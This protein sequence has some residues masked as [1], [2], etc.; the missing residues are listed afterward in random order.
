M[1]LMF[2]AER[3]TVPADPAAPAQADRPARAGAAAPVRRLSV[4][5][6]AY[7]EALRLP[8]F[9]ESIRL[10]FSRTEH[11]AY[12]V[13]VVD[14]GSREGVGPAVEAIARDWPQ[15][16]LLRHP[17]NRGKGAA[18]RTGITAATG[19]AVL[20]ADA[21]GATPIAEEAKLRTALLR[22]ADLAAGSR[23]AADPSSSRTRNPIRGLAGR[24]FAACARLALDL[25][26]SDPQCGFKMV[27]TD[28]A[29]ELLADCDESGYLFDTQLLLQACRRGFR[30][31]D[32]PVTWREVAGS[33][34]RCLRDGPRLFRGVLRLRSRSRPAARQRRGRLS[35]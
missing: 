27:R 9:L 8:P 20:L 22:G 30:V 2:Q 18:L 15:L 34:I 19:C 5:I 28:V 7:N 17:V 16:V 1:S 23:L 3:S 32:V 10:Y 4:V 25:P 14:D 11:V 26:V 24:V 31:A 33:N 35:P 21:D 6:P 13:I 12:E 29:R